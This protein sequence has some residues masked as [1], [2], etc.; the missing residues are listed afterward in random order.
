MLKLILASTSPRRK[1][2]LRKLGI[3]FEI[4][5]P[6]F[7]ENTVP[8]LSP[9]DE[10]LEFAKKKA[11][12]VAHLYPH[13]LILASDTLIELEKTK[14][15]KPKNPEDAVEILKFMRN[16]THL[17]HSSLAFLNTQTGHCD[18]DF[19]TSKVTFKN[20]SD[21][22]LYQSLELD[23]PWDKAGAYAIQ[24]NGGLLIEKIEGDIESGIGLPLKKV[25]DYLE[26]KYPEILKS[27][28]SNHF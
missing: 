22:L 28:R 10:A 16:K 11:A 3:P 15:G 27:K 5:A 13:A 20:F 25:K 4:C 9:L 7:E 2:L 6:L 18:I 8:E 23:Q 21:A 24:D 14:I 19:E 12:S 26:K 17:I 1:H